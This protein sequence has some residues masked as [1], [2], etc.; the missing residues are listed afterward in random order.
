MKTLYMIVLV[1]VLLCNLAFFIGMVLDS[2]RWLQRHRRGESD[3]PFGLHLVQSPMFTW[4]MATMLLVF[5]L[6]GVTQFN[7]GQVLWPTWLPWWIGPILGALILWSGLRTH[8]KVTAKIAAGE[9]LFDERQTVISTQ[10]DRAT[11]W[12]LYLFLLTR[13]IASFGNVPAFSADFF[14][15]LLANPWLQTVAVLFLIN[16]LSSLY[17]TRKLS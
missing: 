12:I 10:A 14:R 8:R 9:K 1:A 13:G 3:L 5:S 16:A 11:L 17:F 7:D 15:L 2:L 4:T 6:T